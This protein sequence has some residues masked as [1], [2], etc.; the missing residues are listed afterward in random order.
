MPEHALIQEPYDTPEEEE[1]LDLRAYWRVLWG[2]KWG[3]LGLAFMITLLAALWSAQ[4]THIFRGT[5]TILIQDRQSNLVSIE[6]VYAGEIDSRGFIPTQIGILKSREMA[7]K[8]V[9]RMALVDHPGFHHVTRSDNGFRWRDYV[10]T[11]LGGQLGAPES[12]KTPEQ[13]TDRVVD[14]VLRALHVEPVRLSQL[15]AISF[16]SRDRELTAQVPNVLTDVYI[17]SDLEAKLGM[18]QKATTWLT[19]RLEGLRG[20]LEAS[21][22]ALQAYR[23]Q[24]GIMVTGSGD[25]TATRFDQLSS[26]LLEARQ[27]RVQAETIY[28]QD[29][30]GVHTEYTPFESPRLCRVAADGPILLALP[31]ERGGRA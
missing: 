16:E 4:L 7:R 27:D 5:A 22:Q 18:T 24:S 13:L 25:T 8:L 28:R 11:W 2:R 14:A 19:E 1:G 10:P 12:P 20:N 31:V 26:R 15:V 23:E 9:E 3:I 21:E 17:E 29:H 6:Q 30:R